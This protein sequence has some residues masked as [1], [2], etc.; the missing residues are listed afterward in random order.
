[1]QMFKLL[2]GKGLPLNSTVL[3][4]SQQQGNGRETAPKPT[5]KV[6]SEGILEGPDSWKALHLFFHHS[7][8]YLR[9][10]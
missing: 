2:L 9:F 5:F 1:M 6:L 3:L 4:Q 7:I 8:N 10:A